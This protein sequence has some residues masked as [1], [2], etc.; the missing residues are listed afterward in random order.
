MR[1]INIDNMG[2]DASSS[3]TSELNTASTSADARI[4]ILVGST[5]A[6]A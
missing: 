3:A 6:P 4:D 2:K 1:K 5:N